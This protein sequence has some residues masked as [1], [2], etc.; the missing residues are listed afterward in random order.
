MSP[1]CCMRTTVKARTLAAHA[2]K[3]LSYAFSNRYVYIFLDIFP[4]HLPSAS[5]TGPTSIL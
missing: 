5:I 4:M 1:I 3:T 2:S